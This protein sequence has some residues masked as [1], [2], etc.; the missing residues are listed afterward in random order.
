M[1]ILAISGSLRKVSSNTVLLRAA[2]RMAPPGVEITL[3]DALEDVPPFNPDKDDLDNGIAPPGVLAFRAAL[4]A[5]DAV[6]ISSPEYAHGLSGVM[7][8]ALDWTVGSGEFS[9]KPTALINASPR[10]LHA[11]GTLMEV[12]RTITFTDVIEGLLPV[13][14][15]GRKTDEESLSVDKDIAPVIRQTLDALIKSVQPPAPVE[16]APIGVR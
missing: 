10:S 11:H 8:N 3:Y 4:Q 16:L 6:L 7:K 14:M 15:S 9:S 2:I 12:L 13:P 5:C 1:K